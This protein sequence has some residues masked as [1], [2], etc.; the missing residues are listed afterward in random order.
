MELELTD[1]QRLERDTFRRWFTTE[2]EPRVPEMERGELL[3]YGLMRD[4]HVGL[5]L[6]ALSSAFAR[7]TFMVEM[8]RVSPS[9]A[10]SYGASTGLFGAN[11][12]GKGTPE[13]VRDWAVPVLRCEKVGSWGLTEP[14][15]GSDALRGMKTTARRDGDHWVLRGSK[16][17]ITNA[18][19]D[20]RRR[21][22]LSGRGT[23]RPDDP[24]E[25]GT[26]QSRAGDRRRGPARHRAGRG[27]GDR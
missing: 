4:M 13:E 3:P 20:A 25:R 26:R 17:F 16:T 9:F 10:L 24:R 12:L 11:V 15:A 2:L 18:P 7:T 27:G 1:E 14:G 22:V 21:T 8:A 19:C 6:E 23:P 5:G